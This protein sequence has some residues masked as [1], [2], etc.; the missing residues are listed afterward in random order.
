MLRL[1]IVASHPVSADNGALSATTRMGAARKVAAK[2]FDGCMV[3]PVEV[4]CKNVLGPQ[5]PRS[6]A[7]VARGPS[8]TIAAVHGAHQRHVGIIDLE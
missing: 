2:R 3:T 1:I 5:V 4:G 8:H 6:F 7:G